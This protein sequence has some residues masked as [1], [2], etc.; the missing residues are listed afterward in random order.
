[1]QSSLNQA[2]ADNDEL[3]SRYQKLES[4]LQAEIAVKTQN[5]VKLQ[6][7]RDRLQEEN[8][9]IQ[10]QLDDLRQQQRRNTAAVASTQENNEKLTAEV[11][12]LRGQLKTNQEARDNA[13]AETVRATDQLHQAQGALSSLRERNLQILQD[14]GAKTALLRGADIDPNADP[15]AAVPR[16]R[17]VVSATDRA[18]GRQ[19]I[20]ITVGSD[21]G[22]Q[23]GHT[24]EVFRGDRYLGRAEIIKTEPDR[25]VGRVLRRFQQGNIQEGDHVA[26]R[27][28]VG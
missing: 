6:T 3:T 17:G 8:A 27:L 22:I 24:V 14:L 23:K 11:E 20:E 7:E 1:M 13:F 19:L 18:P 15:E 28:R 26:T 10:N 2:R 16:V 4:Q 25:S 12:D 21:D 9:E 5:A